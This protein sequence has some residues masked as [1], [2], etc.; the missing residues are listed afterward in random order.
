[1]WT[2]LL[3]SK[4]FERREASRRGMVSWCWIITGWGHSTGSCA[5]H[6][7]W[8][9]LFKLGRGKSTGSKLLRRGSV[10]K[11]EVIL[12]CFETEVANNMYW[13]P[14]NSGQSTA[15]LKMYEPHSGLAGVASF[16]CVH[17]K[18]GLC[19]WSSFLLVGRISSDLGLVGS[20]CCY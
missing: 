1:M 9:V 10:E 11:F 6:W 16:C 13:G 5:S 12:N 18:F 4:V 3:P 17:W 7:R 14:Q 2:Q 20:G 15:I 19:M 8:L